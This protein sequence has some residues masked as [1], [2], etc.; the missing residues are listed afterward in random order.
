LRCAERCRRRSYKT[1]GTRDSIW[2]SSSTPKSTAPP[3][4]SGDLLYFEDLSVAIG[5][6]LLL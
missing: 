3:S 6:V 4:L 1:S 2:S 5:Y